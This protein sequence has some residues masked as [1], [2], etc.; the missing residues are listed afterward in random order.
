MLTATR[1]DGDKKISICG[2]ARIRGI[3]CIAWLPRAH[4]DR[5]QY[6]LLRQKL[7]RLTPVRSRRCPWSAL[8]GK[9]QSLVP[10]LFH[11]PPPTPWSQQVVGPEKRSNLAPESPL[12]PIPFM[13]FSNFIISICEDKNF[14]IYRAHDRRTFYLGH[15]RNISQILTLKVSLNKTSPFGQVTEKRLLSPRSH[16]HESFSECRLV[17]QYPH[18]CC[19]R[20]NSRLWNSTESRDR[21]SLRSAR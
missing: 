20:A 10:P 3:L 4:L 5:L 19:V 21:D 18:E 13:H 15:N 14:S 17:R 16:V 9:M 1:P 6:F 8:L 7:H 11:R 2:H 12:N